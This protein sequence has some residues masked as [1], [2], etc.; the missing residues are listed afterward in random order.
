ME[1]NDELD[2]K[3]KFKWATEVFDDRKQQC[4]VT[5]NLFLS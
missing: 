5:R 4:K 1:K 3:I 2:F